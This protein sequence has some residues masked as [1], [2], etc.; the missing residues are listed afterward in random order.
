MLRSGTAVSGSG[1]VI[2]TFS[3]V[4][5]DLMSSS[6]YCTP[7]KYWLPPTGSIQKFF[8]LNWI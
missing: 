5:I 7:T 8:L 2:G 6:G 1:S 4:S 3:S